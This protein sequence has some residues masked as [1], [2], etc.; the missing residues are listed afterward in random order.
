[1]ACDKGA[2]H[3]AEKGIAPETLIQ[4]RL[5][6]DMFTFAYQVKWTAVHSLGAIEGVRKGVF[7]RTS[8]HRPR[9]SRR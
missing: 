4:A 7:S 2:A 3:C 6:P 9:I 8:C 5:A 1:M